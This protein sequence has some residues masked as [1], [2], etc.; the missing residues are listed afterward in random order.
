M[1]IRVSR[2]MLKSAG[3]ALV[4]IILLSGLIVGMAALI[5]ILTNSQKEFEKDPARAHRVDFIR[6]CAEARPLVDCRSDALLLYPKREG[7]D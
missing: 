3:G 5:Y 6:D 7:T 1:P 2:D 4:L